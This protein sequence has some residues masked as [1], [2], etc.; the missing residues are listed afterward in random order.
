MYKLATELP[1]P[2][3]ARRWLAAGWRR[4]WSAVRG[5]PREAVIWVVG[6]TAMAAAD[7]TA[8]PLI[9]LCL[10]DAVGVS[11]CPGCGLGHAI[12]WLARGD[13][14]ASVQAHP[15]GLPAIGVLLY[16]IVYLVRHP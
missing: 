6:L 11:F 16:R 15:L 14:V 12:A 8:P 10:F 5:V 9:D 4:G 1:R 3:S 2:S 13:V 7:P